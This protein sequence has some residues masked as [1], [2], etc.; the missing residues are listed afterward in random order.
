[1]AIYETRSIIEDCRSMLTGGLSAGVTI[2]ESS[3]VPKLLYNSECWLEISKSSLQQLESVQLQFM[4]V[5]L[6]V[7]QRCSKPHCTGTQASS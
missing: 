7:G 4:R 5:L 6:A 2:W 1:M 3:I